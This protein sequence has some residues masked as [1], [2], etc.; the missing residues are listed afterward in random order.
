MVTT[1][2]TTVAGGDGNGGV[3]DPE[4]PDTVVVTGADVNGNPIVGSALTAQVNCVSTCAPVLNYQWQ[5]ETVPGSA[6]Y[7]SIGT[8][9]DSYTPTKDDQKRKIRVEVTKP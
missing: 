5:I 1:V 2:T 6:V 7:T 8:N 4:G 3:I 9:S